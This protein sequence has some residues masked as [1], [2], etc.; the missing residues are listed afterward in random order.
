MKTYGLIVADRGGNMYVQGTMDSRWDNNVLN[1]AFHSL[2]VSDFEVIK[3]GWQP[4]S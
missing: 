4:T 1:P 3:L 2:H